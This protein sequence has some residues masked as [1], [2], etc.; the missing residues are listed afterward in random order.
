MPYVLF[1]NPAA[2]PVVQSFD[3]LTQLGW[4]GSI[5]DFQDLYICTPALYIACRPHWDMLCECHVD[6]CSV[7]VRK[8]SFVER[9]GNGIKGAAAMMLVRV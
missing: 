4:H 6:L 2:W 5:C 9:S 8:L 7:C 3:T 1:V